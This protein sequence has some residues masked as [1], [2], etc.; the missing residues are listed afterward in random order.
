MDRILL[1]GGKLQRTQAARYPGSAA[2][3][4]LALALAE[5][6]TMTDRQLNPPSVSAAFLAR[7]GW[8]PG[9]PDS[10]GSLIRNYYVTLSSSR[11]WA[12]ISLQR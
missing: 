8:T 7:R 9:E 10:S 6:G 3:Q 12:L 5:L 4:A 2:A 1:C 11:V